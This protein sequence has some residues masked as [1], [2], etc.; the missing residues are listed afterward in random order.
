MT[1]VDRRVHACHVYRTPVHRGWGDRLQIYPP[2][3][4]LCTFCPNFQT[5]MFLCRIYTEIS[6]NLYI[7]EF[8]VG[9]GARKRDHF[10]RAVFVLIMGGGMDRQS[11]LTGSM[12][13][14]ERNDSQHFVSIIDPRGGGSTVNM[15]RTNGQHFSVHINR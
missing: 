2:R 11:T 4:G 1:S 14:M 7:K 10:A 9:H 3:C 12:I 8:N 15:E 5:H 6:T 13:D